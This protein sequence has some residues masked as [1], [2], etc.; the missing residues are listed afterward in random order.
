M[1]SVETLDRAARLIRSATDARAIALSGLVAAIVI[2]GIYFFW[3]L[4]AIT[5]TAECTAVPTITQMT[6]QVRTTTS[7]ITCRINRAGVVA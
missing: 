2:M 5:D 6:V 4:L 7:L 3:N 1:F